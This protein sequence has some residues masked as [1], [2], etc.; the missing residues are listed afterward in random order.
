[1]IWRWHMLLRPFR[2]SSHSPQGSTAGMMTGL[3]LEVGR[4]FHHGAADL[5]AERKW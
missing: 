4:A 5:M 2:Q 3:P 1:M